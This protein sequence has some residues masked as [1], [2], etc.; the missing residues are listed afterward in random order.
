MGNKIGHFR[1]EAGRAS[2]VRAYETA[3]AA[4]PAPSETLDVTTSLGTVR[5]YRWAGADPRLTPVALLP[6]RSSGVPMWSENLPVLLESG[7]AVIA[8]DAIGDAGLSVQTAPLRSFALQATWVDEALDE[9]GA[10]K[11]HAVGHSF[12][13]ATAVAH[14]LRHPDRVATL[15]LLEPVFV[16]RMPPP[17]TYVWAT[18]SMLPVPRRWR[19]HALAKIGGV[20]VE[21]VRADSAIGTMIS[22]GAQQ[23]QAALPNPKPLNDE[24]LALLAMP[25]YVAIAGERSLAGGQRA[26]ARA[27]LLPA[28]TVEIWAGTTH[29]LP[30]QV[31]AQLGRRLRDFWDEAGVP[32]AGG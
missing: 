14:A 32:E 29:S 24:E 7:R 2:Y 3:M 13:G 17:S 25:T 1:S 26:A 10:D 22:V 30:M 11:V 6:G 15:T 20:S 21:D 8:M 16:L 27:E 12:G 28:A 31:H 23:F 4:L 19:D 9:I 18:L 5:A